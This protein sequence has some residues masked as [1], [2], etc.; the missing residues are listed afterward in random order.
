MAFPLNYALTVGLQ[1]DKATT[2][3][4][5]K[6]NYLHQR[7]AQTLDSGLSQ[8]LSFVLEGQS[9][10]TL[11]FSYLTY[12]KGLLLKS[13]APLT[14]VLNDT[15]ELNLVELFLTTFNSGQNDESPLV[16]LEAIHPGTVDS[17]S[18]QVEVTVFGAV[19]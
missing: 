14:L 3:S 13:T 9:S 4:E 6:V 12:P 18:I 19:A 17:A 7:L 1:L 5:S 16:S 2:T 11:D 10:W 8:T 15:T